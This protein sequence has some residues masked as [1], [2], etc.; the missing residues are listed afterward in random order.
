MQQK[1][2]FMAQE[3]NEWYERNKVAILD[4]S[5]ASDPIFKALQYLGRKPARI[6]EIGCANGWRLAQLA[7]HYGARCYGV[8]PSASAIQDGLSRYP[9][10]Q[11]SVGTADCLPVIEPVD[12]IIFG[13]CL[14]LCDPQD[15]FKIAAGSDALLADGGLMT[16]LDFNPPAGHYRNDYQHHANLYSYKMN[17]G[18]LFGWHPGYHRLFE[19]VQ[20]HDGGQELEPDALISVQILRKD[21][22]LLAAQNPYPKR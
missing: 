14:Y 10:V 15:L 3:G 13:F 1:N 5:L 17:Y 4:K 19:H 16:I 2:V 12:L 8:D 6:L 22:R 20:H 21:A 9:G 18:D 7:D 11:L